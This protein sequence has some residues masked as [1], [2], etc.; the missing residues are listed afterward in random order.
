MEIK[1]LFIVYMISPYTKKITRAIQK[2]PKYYLYDWSQITDEGHK[3]E[4]IV[5]SHL[6][7]ACQLWT[8]LGEGNIDLHFIR[9]RIGREVDFLVVKDRKPWFLVETKLA[10]THVDKN[11]KYFC[12]R[13]NVPGLQ[14]VKRKNFVKQHGVVTVVS[15]DRWLAN[16]P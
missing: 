14:V 16:L 8:G 10:E 15:A 13:L 4:N 7:K 2:Q 3:F 1:K 6:W 9:D 11:L 12:N 5:A